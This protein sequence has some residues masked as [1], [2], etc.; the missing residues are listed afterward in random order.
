MQTF[1]QQAQ[2]EGFVEQI[3]H[4]YVFIGFFCY[5]GIPAVGIYYFVLLPLGFLE[6]KCSKR[7]SGAERRHRNSEFKT[8]V[9][10]QA[11]LQQNVIHGLNSLQIFLW[12]GLTTLPANLQADLNLI[13]VEWPK[14]IGQ[15]ADQ[16]T[17]QLQNSHFKE[18]V[19]FMYP[20][21]EFLWILIK[22]TITC[23]CQFIHQQ[24][25]QAIATIQSQLWSLYW[26]KHIKEPIVQVSEELEQWIW[27]ITG[28]PLIRTWNGNVMIRATIYHCLSGIPG[29]WKRTAY[30]IIKDQYR[31]TQRKIQTYHKATTNSLKQWTCF[32]QRLKVDLMVCTAWITDQA[33][34][35][36][37]Q[38]TIPARGA[39]SCLAYDR[40]ITHT[41]NRKERA[42]TNNIIPL[43]SSGKRWLLLALLHLK[44]L[45]WMYE[46]HPLYVTV[47]ILDATVRTVETYEQTHQRAEGPYGT[48]PTHKAPHHANLQPPLAA[49]KSGKW[50]P[51]PGQSNMRTTT[52]LVQR[53]RNHKESRGGTMRPPPPWSIAVGIGY[54]KGKQKIDSTSLM[55]WTN[56][57][58]HTHDDV[59][60]MNGTVHELIR[61]DAS[62]WKK[63]RS[64]SANWR[65]EAYAGVKRERYGAH[66]SILCNF[67]CACVFH[68]LLCT[69]NLSSIPI[70]VG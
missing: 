23:S 64:G 3:R 26:S 30:N 41:N 47:P 69:D 46:P 31:I 60:A 45:H 52:E 5:I 50:I 34:T 65:E 14:G 55:L 32:W 6:Q 42:A 1:L 29:Y 7:V 56:P 67:Y 17:Q 36:V 61:E 38:T 39:H 68:A 66:R 58:I 57:L 63:L 15:L 70:G 33:M 51:C 18:F 10:Q 9:Q 49:S 28:N 2:A 59:V 48:R 43:N 13:A 37:Q 62:Y 16:L 20:I 35:L 11:E 19:E 27:F 8:A 12:Q 24:I 40:N 22:L 44:L 53:L 21:I 4:I 25:V 54:H